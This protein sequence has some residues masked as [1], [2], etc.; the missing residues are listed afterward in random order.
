MRTQ[1]SLRLCL[2]LG[3]V[4][5]LLLLLPAAAAAQH[6]GPCAGAWILSAAG[7]PGLQTLVGV[8]TLT[9]M[10][11]TGRQLSFFAAPVNPL[12]PLA[13]GLLS[14]T[15]SVSPSVGLATRK[16]PAVYDLKWVSYGV[17]MPPIGVFDR[18][19]VQYILMIHSEIVCQAD[20]MTETGLVSVYSAT[21][22][23]PFGDQDDDPEDGMPDAGEAPMAEAPF[24]FV[25]RRL[26]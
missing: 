3:L 7:P 23:G 17:D 25:Y 11:P 8:A 10:S 6:G 1:R 9:P 13:P 24:Q 20:T 22:V 18:G 14:N 21:T 4:T 5:A 16:A 15:D 2:R 26:R 12:R 19:E